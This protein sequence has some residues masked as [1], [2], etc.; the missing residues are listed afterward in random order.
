MIPNPLFPSPFAGGKDLWADVDLESMP[1][2]TRATVLRARHA[3]AVRQAD[4]AATIAALAA[5]LIRATA[6]ASEF[7]LQL[8]QKGTP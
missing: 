5:Q 3:D 6:I 1:P 2:A 8:K 4:Q 7:Q